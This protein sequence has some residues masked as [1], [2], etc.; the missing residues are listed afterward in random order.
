MSR[1]AL[2]WAVTDAL[3]LVIVDVNVLTLV[4]SCECRKLPEIAGNAQSL[5]LKAA[6]GLKWE[7]VLF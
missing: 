3:I 2:V 6:F 7:K 5:S 1:Y 4:L